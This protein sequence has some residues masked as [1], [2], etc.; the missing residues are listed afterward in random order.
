MTTKLI[1]CLDE[2][3]EELTIP[4]PK[5]LHEVLYLYDK[6][7]ELDTPVLIDLKGIRRYLLLVYIK[8]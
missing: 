4:A 5:V 2:N 3:W 7:S 1:C 6:E 8:G